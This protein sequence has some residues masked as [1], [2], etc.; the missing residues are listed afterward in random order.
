[1]FD[2]ER[3]KD[4]PT[5]L[6]L[7]DCIHSRLQ[8]KG[9]LTY[10]CASGNTAVEETKVFKDEDIIYAISLVESDFA[11]R[12]V[13]LQWADVESIMPFNSIIVT[14]ACSYLLPGQIMLE[15]GREFQLNDGVSFIP[16]NLSEMMFKISSLGDSRY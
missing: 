16:L 9:V 4:S 12:G 1:M 10:K 15:R 3:M 5:V 2:M 14:G 7:I 11:F 13:N 6:W 8:S